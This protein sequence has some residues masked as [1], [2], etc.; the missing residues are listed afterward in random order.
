MK[1]KRNGHSVF[2]SCLGL[3]T[4]PAVGCPPR[5]AARPASHGTRLVRTRTRRPYQAL[6][7]LGGAV[8]TH[9]KHAT[10]CC[11]RGRSFRHAPQACRRGAQPRAPPRASTTSQGPLRR[12]RALKAQCPLGDMRGHRSPLHSDV[13]MRSATMSISFGCSFALLSEQMELMKANRAPTRGV[14]Y[15]GCTESASQPRS[16]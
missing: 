2:K 8:A 15:T 10:L 3:G 5:M 4:T 1:D 13:C 14:S 16:D 11:E 7:R 9:L 6:G 12:R